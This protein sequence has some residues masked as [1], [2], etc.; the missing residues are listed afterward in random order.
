MFVEHEQPV[1]EYA[2][3]EKKEATKNYGIFTSVH[4]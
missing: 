4:F 2:R 3:A 1:G